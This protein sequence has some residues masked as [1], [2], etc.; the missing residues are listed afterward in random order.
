[1]KNWGIIC[2]AVVVLCGCQSES[3][4]VTRPQDKQKQVAALVDLGVGYLK[5]GEY[6]RAKDNLNHAL[7]LDYR[8]APAHNALALIF[9]FERE[10]GQA[11]KQF[12][13]ALRYDSKFTRA[14][15]NYGAFLFGQ[16]RFQEAI[17][18]LKIAARDQFYDERPTVFENLGICYLQMQDKK[19]AEDAFVK[20]VALNPKQP[21][22]LLELAEL[23]YDQKQY[24]I[25]RELF[26]RYGRVAHANARS[27]WLC[28]RLSRVFRNSD[29]EASCALALKNIY[30]ASE[31][32]KQYQKMV[33]E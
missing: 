25:S 2:I 10:F 4:L 1:M 27:L 19:D 3:D 18:Q 17:D 30:P 20:S 33:S 15:N 23:R 21:R 16:G 28:V 32:F 9:Q 26:Q 24:V 29:K 14:R 8:S 31:E 7:Q 13:L 5:N 11:E 22:A 6:S 12:K